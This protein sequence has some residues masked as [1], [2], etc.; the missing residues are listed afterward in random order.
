MAEPEE[1]QA[2]GRQNQVAYDEGDYVVRA[3][4]GL[5]VVGISTITA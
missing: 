3:F 4:D 5:R 1:D 2:G